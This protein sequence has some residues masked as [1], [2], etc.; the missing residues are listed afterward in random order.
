MNMEERKIFYS[1]QS[2]NPKTRNFILGNLKQVVSELQDDP[3]LEES[4]RL[5]KDTQGEVGSPDIVFTIERKISECDIFVAD[6]SIIGESNGRQLVNQNVMFELGYA[7][8]KHT[9]KNVLLLANTDLGA[10]KNMP[11]DIAHRRMLPFSMKDAAAKKLF[12]DKLKDALL[13]HLKHLN[14][15]PR[16]IKMDDGGSIQLD[17]EEKLALGLFA[18]MKMDP[19]IQV[20]NTMA[21][22]ST[23]TLEDTV[24]YRKEIFQQMTPREFVANMDSLVEKGVLDVLHGTKH[25]ITHN[26]RPTKTGFKLIRKLKEDGS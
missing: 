3:E 20:V 12:H 26:Y 23:R 10:T 11:F 5:D 13:M 8:A 4:P 25:P 2:D 24:D 19:C 16:L 7:L 22:P 14:T 17:D 9:D 1:W 15:K 18:K 21:G 6:V